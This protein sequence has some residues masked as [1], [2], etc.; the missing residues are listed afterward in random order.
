MLRVDRAEKT[1]NRRV[2]E[3]RQQ[4]AV[5]KCAKSSEK[6]HACMYH[7]IIV[8]VTEGEKTDNKRG[9]KKKKKKTRLDRV[10]ACN[11]TTKQISMGKEINGV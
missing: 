5:D 10:R 8:I 7:A 4:P 1:E 11:H 2:F 3:T 6:K 9:K